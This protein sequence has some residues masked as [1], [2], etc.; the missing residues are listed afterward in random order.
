MY[1]SLRSRWEAIRAEAKANEKAKIVRI[2]AEAGGRAKTEDADR[3]RAWAK[4]E[5]KEKAEIDR[6]TA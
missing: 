3:V 2:A 1:Y 4:A 6:V 5:A